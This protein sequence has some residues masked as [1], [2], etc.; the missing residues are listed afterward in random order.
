MVVEVTDAVP[1]PEALPEE[2]RETAGRALTYMALEPGTPMQEIQLDRIFIG[3]CTN[4]RIGDLRDA[5]RIVEGRKVADTLRAMV[6]PGSAQ[7]LKQAEEEGLDEVFRSAGFEWRTAGCS[8]CLGMNPDTLS[9]GRALRL[10]LEPQLRGPPGQGRAH[11]PGQPADGRGRRDRGPL[12]RHP[13]VVLSIAVRVATRPDNPLEL[14][15]LAAGQVPRPLFEGY[16]GLMAARTL[17]AG[18]SLGIFDALQE[19]PDDAAGLARAPRPRRAGRRRAAR[20][21][22]LDELPALPRRHLLQL[23]PGRAPPRQGRRRAA[24]RDPRQLLL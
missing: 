9:P 7:V 1:D 14:A 8:M 23:A 3:S 12:R 15:A 11:P 24:A 18:T 17:M 16:F 6:V 2:Q 10:D 4:S 20:R 13:R 5:A 22:A 19:R 21:P